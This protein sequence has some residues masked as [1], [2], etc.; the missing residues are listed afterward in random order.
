MSASLR[1][2]T[3]ATALSAATRRLKAAGVEQPR[4]DARLLLSDALGL[5]PERTLVEPDRPIGESEWAVF[6]AFVERRAAREPVSRI[7]GR[8]EFWGLTFRISPDTLDPRPDSE[9]LIEVA[10]ERLSDRR[11]PSRLLDLGTGSGCLLL[12]LL[13]ELP[14]AVGLGLDI[15]TGAVAV[16]RGNALDLG[17]SGRAGFGVADWT[18]GVTGPFDLVLCNPPY[19]ARDAALEPEVADYDPPNA[20]YAGSDGLTAYRRLLPTLSP[21][22]APEGC[23]LLELGA[24]QADA[25][26]ALGE[27]AGFSDMTLRADLSGTLRCLALSR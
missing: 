2:R 24:G 4:R 10:L 11:A 9:T 27:A 13:S 21:L 17:L 16:A 14:N 7:L 23:V 22:L 3:V 18:A 15:S 19:I 25:V 12:A 20:L 8:R 5:A 1:E 26:A 6:Q